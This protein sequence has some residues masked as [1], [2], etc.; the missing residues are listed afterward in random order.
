MQW[1]EEDIEHPD[2][3]WSPAIWSHFVE[4]VYVSVDIVMR[5]RWN[6]SLEYIDG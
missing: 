6:K 2:P 1:L 5:I 4:I 3:L